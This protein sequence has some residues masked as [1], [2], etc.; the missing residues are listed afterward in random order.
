[1]RAFRTWRRLIFG[2]KPVIDGSLGVPND[3]NAEEN[4]INVVF[5]EKDAGSI[6]GF[7]IQG[8]IVGVKITASD[9]L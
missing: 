4:V 6:H 3:Y 8:G 2:N 1:M 5:K 7:I 9:P